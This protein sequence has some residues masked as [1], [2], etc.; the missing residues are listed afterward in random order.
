M[1]RSTIGFYL[2]LATLALPTL[3]S[4]ATEQLCYQ[5]ACA[6]IT[7]PDCPPAGEPLAV[8]I[9]GEL[10]NPHRLS[11]TA[12]Q[13]I[14]NARWRYTENHQVQLLAGEALASNGFLFAS[15]F[16]DELRINRSDIER[17]TLVFGPRSGSHGYYDV[18]LDI[19]VAGTRNQAVQIDIKPGSCPNPVN[20]GK[21]GMTPVAVVG[22]GELD[23]RR[24][25]LQSVQLAGIVP[26]R[27][28][29]E[30]V[31][32]ATD[33]AGWQYNCSSAGADGTTD[34]TLKFPTLELMAAL[35][36]QLGRP[37]FDGEMVN[38]P[39]SAR[40]KGANQCG[41]ELTGQETIQVISKG[42]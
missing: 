39:F 15:Q 28:S 41:G 3:G 37:L 11:V 20:T 7:V 29:Y 22:S 38:V 18:A 2:L 12:Y 25:D 4:A 1:T 21:R 40:L 17:L 14:A 5:D 24:I 35:E 42:R 16:S 19:A 36:Q 31:A 6:R 33:P 8:A 26:V 32:T 34:L 27:Y 9:G 30:D 23:V 10:Q 13:L